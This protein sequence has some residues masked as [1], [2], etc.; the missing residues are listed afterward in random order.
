[1]EELIEI[2]MEIDPD[3]DYET[4][5]TLVDDGIL[6]SFELVSLVS[7]I[8]ETFGVRIPPEQIIPENFN[9]AAGIYKLI[10]TLEGED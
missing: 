7:Q 4:Y 3:I 1:M 2:L 10:E 8:A 6:T 9:S 5:E